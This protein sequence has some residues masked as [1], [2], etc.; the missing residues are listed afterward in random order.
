[1]PKQITVE[2]AG[3]EYTIIERPARKN[4]EW[5]ERLNNEFSELAAL[6]VNAPNIEIDTKA[7][8]ELLGNLVQ[9]FLRHVGGSVDTLRGLLIEYSP[10]L[11]ADRSHIEES[12]YDSEILAAFVEVLKLAYPFGSLVDLAA[13]ATRR[14]GQVNQQT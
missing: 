14:V 10:A 8:M 6:L 12:G 5:R 4:A 3:R 11:V 2:L 9:G 13:A 7:G 1:M